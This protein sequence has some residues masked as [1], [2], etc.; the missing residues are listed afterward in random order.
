MD[1]CAGGDL[2]GLLIKEDVLPEAWVRFYAAEAVM[3]IY[4]CHR[5]G[6]IH[7]DL[8][9]DN[10]LFDHRGHLKLT[11]LGLCKKLGDQES[12]K[13]DEIN[14]AISALP[15]VCA[16][17]IDLFR[18]RISCLICLQIPYFHILLRFFLFNL[19]AAGG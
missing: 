8:K 5:M 3:A 14:E 7:R 1:F 12:G 13:V 11:D 6:Y 18:G 19:Y 4:S 10:F 17:R 9:P 15:E 2:M 16:L